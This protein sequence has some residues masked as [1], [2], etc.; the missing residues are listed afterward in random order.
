[1][2]KKQSNFEAAFDELRKIEGGYVNDKTDRGGETKF[3]ISKRAYPHLNIAE[4]TLDEA[5]EL[6]KKDYW[7]NLLLDNCDS[8]PVAHK[9]FDIGVNMGTERAARIA[10]NALVLMGENVKIDGLL[11]PL[12]MAAINKMVKKYEM[13]YLA[14]LKGYQFTRYRNIVEADGSQQKFIKGWLKR[15]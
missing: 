13:A 3:G 11:G 5:T 10:Q 9:L 2:A 12:T 8:A 15:V 14:A 6:F 7:D 4:L 1:M